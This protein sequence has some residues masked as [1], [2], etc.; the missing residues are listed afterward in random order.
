MPGDGEKNALLDNIVRIRS[1]SSTS[2]PIVHVI[3]DHRNARANYC[4]PVILGSVIAAVIGSLVLIGRLRSFYSAP[5]MPTATIPGSKYEEP[6]CPALLGH[7][8]SVEGPGTVVSTP[9]TLWHTRGNRLYL[10]NAPFYIKVSLN[11]I[12]DAPTNI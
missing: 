1:Y 10:D 7:D 4:R 12:N 5:S 6:S 11:L 9:R 3:I 2:Q 8:S